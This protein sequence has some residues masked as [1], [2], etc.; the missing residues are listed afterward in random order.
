[1]LAKLRLNQTAVYEQ[2]IAAFEISKMLCAFVEGKKHILCIGAEQG[3]IVG[4][5]DFIIQNCLSEFTHLQIKRQQTDFT[6]LS[7]CNRI[8]TTEPTP[9]DRSLLSLANWISTYDPVVNPKIHFFKLCVPHDGPLI[10]QNLE[11]RNLRDFMVLHIN[12]NTTTQGLFNLQN[13]ANDGVAKNIYSWLTTWCGF[14]DWDHIRK[15]LQRLKIIDYR[16]ETDIDSDS[17]DQLSRI[18]NNPLIVLSLIKSYTQINSAYTSSISPRQLLFE[19]KDYLLDTQKTWTQINNINGVWEIS[20]IHDLESNTEVERPAKIIPLLWSNN[21]Y[22]A[23]HI[24]ISQVSSSLAPIHEGIFQLAIHLQGNVNALCANWD[25]WKV[26]LDSK[27][28]G[29]LGDK[30]DDF[31]TLTISG[32]SAP[33]NVTGGMKINSNAERDAFGKEMTSQMIRTTWKLVS[34][35]VSEKIENMDRGSQS[36]ELRDAVDERWKSWEA[37]LDNDMVTVTNLFKNIVHPNA[38]GRDILGYLRI[39][40]KT[41]L[42]IADALF[43][44]LLVSVALDP[45]NLG[46]LRT[47]TGLT[48]GAIGV[49][50]WSGPSGETRRVREID[51]E[52]SVEDLIG[53][54]SSDIL[55]LSQSKQPENVIYRLPLAGSANLDHSLAAGRRPKLLITRNSLF[56]L[57]VK[58]GSISEL[59]N[60]LEQKINK[61]RESLA[62]TINNNAL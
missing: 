3:D 46:L 40:P 30:E 10:K 29:T 23:F 62:G 50:L 2:T 28:G 11:L 35:K 7:S 57:V 53:K 45:H 58:K 48:I 1:M 51:D 31:D 32:N 54:E 55:I 49:R 37:D 4:W 9:L 60:Y 15:A 34:Q 59:R 5:D 12:A 6:P 17:I 22:R 47:E 52:D 41:K 43:T 20:G 13:V 26:C 44:L 16:T 36:Q 24:N 61:H 14:S 56:N 8:G 42:I 19:L 33:Y 39:G 25:G 38:E 21:R 18:F 27:L